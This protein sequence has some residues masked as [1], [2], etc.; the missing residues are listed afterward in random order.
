MWRRLTKLSSLL[1]LLGCA[2]AP[3]E[4]EVRI[5]A[6]AVLSEAAET[7]GDASVDQAFSQ[8]LPGVPVLLPKDH[9]PHPSFR[10]EWWYWT[11]VLWRDHGAQQP[12]DHA[13]EFGAQLVFFRRALAP[14]PEPEGW[15]AT[16]VYMSH[17]AVTHVAASA[18]KH[19]ETLSRAMPG[20]RIVERQPFSIRMPGVSVVSLAQAFAPLQVAA[21]ASGMS[22]DVRL[23]A[24]KP[25]LL[26]GEN[27]FSAKSEDAASHYYSMPRLS[28]RGK[29]G[30]ASE[31]VPVLGWAWL[32]REWSSQEL[33]RGLVGW[34]WMAL[35][36]T[37]GSEIMLYRLVRT[38]GSRDAY[39]Y[40]VH[41]DAAGRLTQF[42]SEAFTMR[43]L[44][45]IEIEGQ[46][47]A[48]EWQVKIDGL[49]EF[50]VE[51]AVDDQYLAT[52]IGYWEGLV[53][54]ADRSGRYIGDGYLEMT[55]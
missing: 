20:A 18:H 38:D 32:D 12:P 11:F 42:K 34:D 2:E 40:A 37:S 52:T 9:G 14:T 6:A 21:E 35:N 8:V 44:R 46:D 1:L 3:P 4:R 55:R 22:L 17:F 23:D 49:G 41:R 48:V 39:N 13:A 30:W 36:L 7:Q 54:V 24:S 27:G 31:E 33:P 16:Q 28:V 15:R 26:Q 29:L 19:K 45:E 51:A 50:H 53:R 5:R 25:P 43:P 10:Q 47:F